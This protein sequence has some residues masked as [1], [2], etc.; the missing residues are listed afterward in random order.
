MKT[1]SKLT[2]VVTLGMT[3]FGT[4]TFLI[5]L[6]LGLSSPPPMAAY[7][8]ARAATLAEAPPAE[9]THDGQAVAVVQPAPARPAP[10]ATSAPMAA[11]L[12]NA[13]GGAADSTAIAYAPLPPAAPTPPAPPQAK[14]KVPAASQAAAP[15]P[16]PAAP[17]APLRLTEAPSP[18]APAPAPAA[19]KPEVT[20]PAPQAQVASIP[21]ETMV[22]VVGRSVPAPVH[23]VQV[24]RFLSRS[25]A[26]ALANDLV[27]HDYDARVVAA[28][29]L[30]VPTKADWYLVTIGPQPDRPTA[31]RVAR[32]VSAAM[33]LPAQ[34]VSWAAYAR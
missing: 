25:S 17:G 19:R 5:G 24:G 21:D 3:V 22:E 33:G 2:L 32:E 7:P 30:G 11:A 10:A 18:P 20:P 28:Q 16:G 26:E 29:S 1:Q 8:P 14:A 13:D 6:L 23:A 9:A 15:A 4:L 27:A 12:A 31:D 34:P